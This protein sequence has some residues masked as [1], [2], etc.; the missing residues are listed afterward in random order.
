MYDVRPGVS[1]LEK[2]LSRLNSR[3]VSSVELEHT[4]DKNFQ[5]GRPRSRAKDHTMRDAEAR[6][7]TSAHSA[8]AVI[9][10]AITAAPRT[11]LVAWRNICMKGNPVGES[12]AAVRSP[13]QKSTAMIIPNPMLPLITRVNIMDRGTITE[14]R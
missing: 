12:K 13:R 9:I 1:K 6:K 11:D 10:D 14:G 2:P 5:P 7:P 3:V 8:R 4:L